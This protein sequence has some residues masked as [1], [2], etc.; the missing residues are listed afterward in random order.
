MKSEWQ[1]HA[2]SAAAADELAA[3]Q[4]ALLAAKRRLDIAVARSRA[5]GLSWSAVASALG[6]T[7][8]SAPTLDGRNSDN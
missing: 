6:I 8:Q 1:T 5:R 3:A 4:N 2:E 7:R